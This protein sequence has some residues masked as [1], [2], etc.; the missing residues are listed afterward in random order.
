LQKP[1]ISTSLNKHG[2]PFLLKVEGID[3]Y[4]DELKPDLV[5]DAGELRARPSKI[6][7]IRDIN[8]IIVLRK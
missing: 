5:L 4:F 1:I 8:N 7:D 6:L 3:N 2:D